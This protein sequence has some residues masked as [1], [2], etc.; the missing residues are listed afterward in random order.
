MRRG[1]RK[2]W[3]DARNFGTGRA[4]CGL[5]YRVLHRLA[6][7]R[8]LKVMKVTRVDPR[9]LA[10][11]A[12]YGYGFLSGRDLRE[13]TADPAHELSE[14]FLGEA[15]RRGEECF[16]VLDGGALAAYGWY[17]HRATPVYDDLV[18]HFDPAFVFMYKGYTHP[19]YRGQ[20]LHAIGKTRALAAFL[21]RGRRGLVSFVEADNYRSLKSCYRMGSE[22]VGRIYVAR[23]LGR[24][25]IWHTGACRA[26]GVRLQP[27]TDTSA[28]TSARLGT[29]I[30]DTAALPRH[31]P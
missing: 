31:R 1:L 29:W 23:L 4:L 3:D 19:A 20:R 25:H 10:G 8:L 27:A 12:P 7:Y 5:A 6:G 24:P 16:G 2:T 17:A 11:P 14:Q 9:F 21:E 22:D 15:E 26:Y 18:L 28:V 13:F 30:R